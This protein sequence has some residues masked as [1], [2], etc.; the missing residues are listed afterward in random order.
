MILQRWTH[1]K[2][3]ERTV[4]QVFQVF[5]AHVEPELLALALANMLLLC[6]L[7]PPPQ[8]SGPQSTPSDLLGLEQLLSGRSTLRNSY[9]LLLDLFASF[10]D[11]TKVLEAK[12]STAIL[13]FL[14][15]AVCITE[16]ACPSEGLKGYCLKKLK[17]KR[18]GQPARV[19]AAEIETLVGNFVML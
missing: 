19:T 16:S 13:Q 11:S 8:V 12:R 18:P 9:K 14:S 15:G 4:R 2:D 6:T 17:G 3:G 10:C 1:T 5:Q 7:N